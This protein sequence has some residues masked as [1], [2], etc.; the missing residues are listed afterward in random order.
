MPPSAVRPWQPPPKSTAFKSL[1]SSSNGLNIAAP[2]TANPMMEFA[3][4]HCG[5]GCPSSSLSVGFCGNFTKKLCSSIAYG[6]SSFGKIPTALSG[7]PLL[8]RVCVPSWLR[9]TPTLPNKFGWSRIT[10][11]SWESN[12]LASV[13]VNAQVIVAITTT[14]STVSKRTGIFIFHMI[15]SGIVQ[16]CQR[17][18]K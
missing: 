2:F 9:P 13:V 15:V 12:K 4:R 14:H 3:G 10:G 8:M 16:A 5:C 11:I 18:N 6:L 17:Y 1:P 7:I